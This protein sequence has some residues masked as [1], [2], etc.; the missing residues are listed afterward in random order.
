MS[1]IVHVGNEYHS[2]TLI[3]CIQTWRIQKLIA[4]KQLDLQIKNGMI[5]LDCLMRVFIILTLKLP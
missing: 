4:T 3:L 5:L 2:F 1:S